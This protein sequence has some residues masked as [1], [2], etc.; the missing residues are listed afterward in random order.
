MLTSKLYNKR[1]NFFNCAIKN[2]KNEKLSELVVAHKINKKVFKKVKKAALKYYNDSKKFSMINM[3]PNGR[4]APKVEIQKSFNEFIIEYFKLIESIK[5]DKL[6]KNYLP[7]VIRYK[8]N[9]PI[10]LIITPE[11]IVIAINILLRSETNI[12]FNFK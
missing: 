5:I 1:V 9:I 3:T 12:F 10:T 6:L 7:P 8:E 4:L 11:K 2:F